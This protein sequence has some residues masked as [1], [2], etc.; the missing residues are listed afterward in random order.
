LRPVTG[1]LTTHAAWVEVPAPLT[2]SVVSSNV[3]ADS[4]DG[5]LGRPIEY[6]T[7]YTPSLLRPMDRAQQRETFGLGGDLPFSGEDVWTGFELSWLNGKGKPEVSGIR[8]R[9]PCT[10]VCIVESKSLKLYLN[11]YAQTRFASMPEVLTTLNSDLAVAFRAP[12][13]VELLGLVQLRGPGDQ[14]PGVCLDDLDIGTD[15]YERNPDLL[16]LDEGA[17]RAVNETVHSHL[18]R[19]VCPVTGQPDWASMMLRYVGRP[20][21]REALLQYLVSF[22]CHSAFHE[23][24]VEQIF[25]DLMARCRPDQ[26]SVCGYF[27]RRGGV[28]ITPFR[29]NFEAA[30]LPI[31]L[32]RS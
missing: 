27:L 26:L 5:L 22:R 31:R 25:V 3:S 19:S 8:I 6:P 20:I 11:S 14:L 32:P 10:S 12:V 28:E 1:P 15:E 4:N 17:D 2:T 30:A 7:I 9:V 29:S 24:T 21:N 23:T 18:F 13:S 16:Q